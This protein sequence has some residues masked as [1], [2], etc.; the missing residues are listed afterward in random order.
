VELFLNGQSLGKQDMPKNL[1]L[2]WKVKYAPGILSAKG[3][4]AG[5]KIIAETKVE[6]TG[7]AAAIQLTP[8]RAAIHADGED[9]SVVAVSVTDAQGRIVPVATNKIHFALDGPGKIIGVGNGDPSCHEPDQ[10]FSPA[11]VREKSVDSWHWKEISNAWNNNL[12]EMAENFDDSGWP[13]ANVNSRNGQL[14]GEG[15]AAFRTQ[16]HLSTN[17]LDAES[18]EM[19]FSA[20]STDGFIFING[21]KAGESRDPK[22]PA[23]V[24]V[25]NFLHPGENTI[26]V[27]VANYGGSGGVNR[28][29]TLRFTQKPAAID[30]QR[31][32]FNGLAEVLVQSTREPGEIKLTATAD[33]LTPTV[34]NLTAQPATPRPAIA[35]GN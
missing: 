31:S 1:H 34:L 23:T 24:D 33:G 28:G 7:D 8:D 16:I 12:P 21:Q 27:A 11:P 4:D 6:T 15:S 25:K 14:Q 17:D 22:T 26:A 13:D 9:I 2:E 18:I 32:V 10:F 35:A 30:W 5:G 29:V 3:F 20:I 19:T